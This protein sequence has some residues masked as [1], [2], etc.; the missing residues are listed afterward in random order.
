MKTMTSWEKC[1]Y[2]AWLIVI[3]FLAQSM[4]VAVTRALR[5][6]GPGYGNIGFVTPVLSAIVGFVF[7]TRLMSPSQRVLIALLYFPVMYVLLVF[8]SLGFIGY[9]YG[10]WP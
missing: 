7:M 6:L 3:P 10:D 8:F 2:S 5:Y 9:V 4:F 1:L